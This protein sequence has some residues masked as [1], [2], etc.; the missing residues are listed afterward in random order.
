MKNGRARAKS[1]RI[2]S[3]NLAH[4]AGSKSCAA[5]WNSSRHGQCQSNARKRLAQPFGPVDCVRQPLNSNV[6]RL[7]FSIVTGCCGSSP[8]RQDL[9]MNV[10]FQSLPDLEF[11]PV[12]FRSLAGQ[13]PSRSADVT[14][15]A[16][17]HIRLFGDL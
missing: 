10:G 14:S 13:R 9:P 1:P 2:K 17:L 16:G 4:E 8:V 7:L 12:N 11:R 3:K 15:L 6:E 5:G